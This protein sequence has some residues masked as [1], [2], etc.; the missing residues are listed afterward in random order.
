VIVLALL[1]TVVPP[2]AASAGP[3]P[4]RDPYVELLPAW[5]APLE[6]QAAA[7]TLPPPYL[8][9][10]DVADAPFDNL[11]A[12]VVDGLIS[13]GE[14]AGAGKVV[15]PGY[16]GD[17]EVFLNHDAITLYV[18]FELPDQVNYIPV[19]DVSLFV[20]TNNDGGSA[21]QPDDFWFKIM[22]NGGVSEWQGNGSG[23]SAGTVTWTGRLTETM[24][25]WSVE[26]GIPFSK[27]GISPG[28]FKELG[29]RCATVV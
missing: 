20:D 13:P 14:Y 12:P 7:Q 23:W 29:W 4:P 26:F 28:T 5:A 24:T 1:A 9:D 17:V 25:G 19:P 22:R 2:P 27:L 6:A 3:P 15:F 10:D 18:A 8:S 11:P 16:G 21:P